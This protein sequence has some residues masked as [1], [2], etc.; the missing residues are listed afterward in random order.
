MQSTSIL[1]IKE[2][3][4]AELNGWKRAEVIGLCIIFTI[5]F[6]NAIVVKDSIIA[7]ISAVCGILYST[8]AGKGKVSC[9]FFGLTGT[10]CYSW[11]AFDNGLW[12][13]LA[14][15]MCYYFP[16]QIIGI[17][18]WRK[19]LK[20]ETAEIIKKQL[21]FYERLKLSLAALL[22]CI[23][24]IVMLYYFKD[25]SPVFDGITTVLSVFGMYL[26]VK[27]CIE[28]WIIWMVVNGLSSLMWLNLVMHG[29]KTYATFIMWVV[30]FILA[31]Y[32]YF[33]WEKEIGERN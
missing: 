7:V 9:Y 17:L 16:M 4:K 32:F 21:T 20:K 33:C 29:A 19:H 26:T 27:R 15:Y 3:V 8:I 5:I 6:V 23:G 24:V 28:Q 30:Y 31:V 11:L 12:G 13:N 22:A 18:A 2:F 14:L 25:S 1:S 10:C